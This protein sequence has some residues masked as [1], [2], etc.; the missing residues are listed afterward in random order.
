MNSTIISVGNELLMGKTLNTNLTYIAKELRKMGIAVAKAYTIQ[1]HESAIRAALKHADDPIIIL[2]GGLGPTPDDMTKEVVCAY[3]GLEMT[4]HEE[5]LHAIEQMFLKYGKIMP[6]SNRKQ[7]LFPTEADI[8]ENPMGTAP[9]MLIKKGDQTFILL[10]GPPNEMRPMFDLVKPLLLNQRDQVIL[11]EG[12]LVAGIGESEME[13]KLDDFAL[14][15]P[16]VR[17]APYAGVGEIQYI[18][19]STDESALKTALEAFKQR[20][21]RYIMG[22]YTQT[23]EEILVHEL[24]QRQET[25]SAIE[26]CT[27][28]LFSGRLGN[29]SGV[30]EVFKE[31]YVLYDNDV[32]TRLLDLHPSVIQSFGVVSKEAVSAMAEGLAKKTQADITLAISGIAGPSGGTS[33]QPVGTVAFGIHYEGKTHTFERFFPGDRQTIRHRSVAY[34]LYLLICQVKRHGC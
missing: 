31:S 32:K 29:V 10:P 18:F 12:F 5:S 17:I 24:T 16:M 21:R 6:E 27:T 2:T 22:P 15:H 9:G 23:F 20:F 34:A 13:D 8:L 14:L 33:E 30:S 4:L 3:L 25:I 26:S 28:G 19:S 7:A 11:Q 1:D